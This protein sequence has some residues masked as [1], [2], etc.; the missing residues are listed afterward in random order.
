M[1]RPLRQIS[2]YKT[3]LV[4]PVRRQ[5]H[6]RAHAEKSA[7]QPAADEQR[8]DRDQARDRDRTAGHTPSASC[9]QEGAMT[10]GPCQSMIE[11]K[12]APDLI[13]GGNRFFE[14]IIVHQISERRRDLVRRGC[15]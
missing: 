5:M 4:T 11:K 12:P 3:I 2:Q 7:D 15:C 9:A 14:E 10:V 1:T 8:G 13:Q 6:R